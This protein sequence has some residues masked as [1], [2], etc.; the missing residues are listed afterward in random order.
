M[1]FC[2]K[3]SEKFVVAFAVLQLVNTV[4]P[5]PPIAASIE[6]VLG[7]IAVINVEFKIE[8]P[9]PIDKPEPQ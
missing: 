2:E 8:Q 5:E 9:N 4:W 3:G 7:D 1:V 6:T